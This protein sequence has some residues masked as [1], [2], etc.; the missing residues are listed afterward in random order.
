[1]PKKQAQGDAA[2]AAEGSGGLRQRKGSPKN[3]PKL[4]ASKTDGATVPKE[5][6][7]KAASKWQKMMKR[8]GV[9]LAIMA[10][11]TGVIMSD[12]M[13][14][15]ISV[16]VLQTLVFGE[17]VAVRQDVKMETR[18]I[19][20]F[21]SLNW[22][23]YGISMFF[24]YGKQIG[25]FYSIG[26]LVQYHFYLVFCLY[27]VFFMGFVAQ[28]ALTA[29]RA[30]KN[31]KKVILYKYQFNQLAWTLFTIFIVVFQMA[32]ITQHIFEGVFWFFLP[33]SLVIMND[34]SAYFCGFFMGKKFI[35]QPLTALSP[36]KT[37]EGFLGAVVCTVIWGWVVA[38]FLSS[39]DWFICP[40]RQYE[41][42]ANKCTPP[43]VFNQ[44]T[45]HVG[46]MDVTARPVQLHMIPLALFASLIAPF[47]GFL[48]SGIKRAYNVKDFGTMIPGHGGFMDRMDCQ[49]IMLFCTHV[50]YRTFIRVLPVTVEVLTA[51]MGVLTGPEQLALLTELQAML[52]DK[53]L[54]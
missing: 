24:I 30:G 39:W 2:P 23:G 8:T 37:W 51:S 44:E 6:E 36:N 38:D 49:F 31:D 13:C 22:Y 11:A 16:A 45:Y 3:S 53:G 7:T 35:K 43:P 19:P 26:W 34:T 40:R 28:L 52:K 27:I 42:D 21:R 12:H 20:L 47:G 15:V 54:M 41:V 17:L 25:K 10:I 48:A 46:G 9:A 32:F 33:C 18:K 50:H 1:M 29:A 4:E 5:D 14:I